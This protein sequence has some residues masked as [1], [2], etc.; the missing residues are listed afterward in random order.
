MIPKR[1]AFIA[2]F[3]LLTAISVALPNT[4]HAQCSTGQSGCSGRAQFVPYPN[5]AASCFRVYWQNGR[6]GSS[7]FCVPRG[8]NHFMQ[9][10]AGDTFCDWNRN[11]HLP[12]NCNRKWINVPGPN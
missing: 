7:N 3:A 2:G 12:D 8:Q 10:Q 6:N 5:S 4:A 9:V 1:D 11:E